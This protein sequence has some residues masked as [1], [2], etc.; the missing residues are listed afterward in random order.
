ML[1]IFLWQC[2]MSNT[3]EE[4]TQK[5]LKITEDHTKSTQSHTKVLTDR[6]HIFQ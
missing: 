3:Y 5:F 4:R 6:Q 1:S 2:S